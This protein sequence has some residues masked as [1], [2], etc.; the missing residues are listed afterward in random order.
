MTGAIICLLIDI[1]YCVF[2]GLF[3]KEFIVAFKGKRYFTFGFYLIVAI[4]IAVLE[5]KHVL[6][7]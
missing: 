7:L 2:F 3:V 4:R 1:L 5:I 6:M